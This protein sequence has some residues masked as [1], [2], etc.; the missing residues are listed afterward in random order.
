MERQKS[1]HI[2]VTKEGNFDFN[3]MYITISLRSILHSGIQIASE[4]QLP[5]SGGGGEVIAKTLRLPVKHAK[6]VF[7]VILRTTD[8]TASMN[9]CA[10][11]AS[12]ASPNVVRSKPFHRIVS[13]PSRTGKKACSVRISARTCMLKSWS[14]LAS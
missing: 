2:K 7:S 4:E 8:S 3:H 10:L 9:Y 14:T 5:K 12:S 1:N 11:L 6:W 13:R